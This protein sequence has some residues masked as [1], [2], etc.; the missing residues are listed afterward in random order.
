[1]LYARRILS[2]CLAVPLQIETINE[3]QT[4]SVKQGSSLLE[5]DVSLLS[6]VAVGDFV[7]VHAGYAIEVLELDEAE[8]RLD[9]FDTLNSENGN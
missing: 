7:I 8:A 6:D 2:M 1:M 3:N 5:V 9:M 4:A